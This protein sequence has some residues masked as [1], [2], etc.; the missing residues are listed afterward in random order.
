MLIDGTEFEGSL[1]PNGCSF[2]S[3]LKF[4]VVSI[5]LFANI[6]KTGK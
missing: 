3:I 6:L 1:L 4:Q 5:N 2:Y